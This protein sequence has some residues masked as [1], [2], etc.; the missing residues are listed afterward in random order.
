MRIIVLA[1]LL[2]FVSAS[3]HRWLEDKPAAGGDKPAAPA[4]PTATRPGPQ[5]GGQTAPKPQAPKP[6]A[7]APAGGA[8]KPAA[9]P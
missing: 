2:I 3:T 5:A 6:S 9:A 7:G 8:P 1:L 4:A